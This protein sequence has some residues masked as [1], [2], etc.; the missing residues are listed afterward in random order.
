MNLTI[1][2]SKSHEPLLVLT[3]D[4]RGMS[5]VG[6]DPKYVKVLGLD[7]FSNIKEVADYINS[8]GSELQAIFDSPQERSGQEDQVDMDSRIKPALDMIRAL[9]DKV[10]DRKRREKVEENS[11]KPETSLLNTTESEIILNPLEHI[12]VSIDGDNIGNAVARAEEMDDEETLSD[13]SNRI[14]AGQDAMK[15]WA[16]RMGGYVVE[17]GGDEGVLKV[18]ATAIKDVE[19]LRSIYLQAVGATASVG[20]GK[21]ISESTKARVV[22]KLR[23][24]DQAVVYDPSIPHEMELRLKDKDSMEA[25]KLS[26]AMR[27]A[28]SSNPEDPKQIEASTVQTKS[29][30]P[31]Q[32]PQQTPA[33]ERKEYNGDQLS[34]ESVQL[35]QQGKVESKPKPKEED[36]PLKVEGKALGSI[37]HKLVKSML[38]EK[39]KKTGSK[40]GDP[41]IDDADY[42]HHDDPEFAKNFMYLIK[43]G[44]RH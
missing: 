21:K 43:H 5:V 30:E 23:G 1:I 17:Q 24:K 7:R 22:A 10:N 35:V 37:D 14:N 39:P 38:S 11:K 26:E 25:R 40:Y 18:P 44:G 34:P 12:Y 32:P 42:S 31:N 36:K 41:E 29:I 15:E 2:D 33:K 3:E 13:I 9:M 28:N 19:N 20:I 27:P 16:I 8:A 6:G 4:D